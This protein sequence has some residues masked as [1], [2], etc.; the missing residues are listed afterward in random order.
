MRRTGGGANVGAAAAMTVM[1]RSASLRFERPCSVILA[2]TED[3]VR[4]GLRSLLASQRGFEIVAEVATVTE[5]REAAAEHRPALLVIAPAR[6]EKIGLTEC[7]EIL[8]RAPET[9]IVVLG[10]RIDDVSGDGRA[11]ALSFL[12]R[13][14]DPHGLCRALRD[15][16]AGR[17]RPAGRSTMGRDVLA[18]TTQERRVLGLVARGKT[19]KEIGGALR[20]SEKTVK[21]YLAH[22][23]EKLHVSRRAQAAVLFA[24]RYAA[25]NGGGAAEPVELGA[26]GRHPESIG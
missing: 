3:L 1:P 8:A 15:A 5:A 2:G 26:G 12:S 6:A 4:L 25:W 9:R 13:S 17:L 7:L 22:A 11:G 10:G 20:L 18:L 19:N 21:N 23:F 24:R 14:L 16:A